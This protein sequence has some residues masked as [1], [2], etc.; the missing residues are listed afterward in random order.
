VNGGRVVISETMGYVLDGLLKR[1]PFVPFD[2]V[3]ADGR[4]V[5]VTTAEQAWVEGNSELLYV[6]SLKESDGPLTEIVALRNVSLVR[7][8]DRLEPGSNDESPF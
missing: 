7:V 6:V 4:V 5:K 3:I 8:K 1:R 2:L